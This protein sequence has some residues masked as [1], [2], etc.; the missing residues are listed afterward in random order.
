MS[1]WT[2]KR[3]MLWRMQ[4]SPSTQKYFEKELAEAHTTEL[5][6]NVELPLVE[7]LTR[8]EAEGINLNV[9]FLKNFSKTLTA[10]IRS[11]GKRY[12]GSGRNF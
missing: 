12:F 11:F 1:L 2:N 7:V 9:D 10:D 8:M 6:K 5:F 4:T 3:N